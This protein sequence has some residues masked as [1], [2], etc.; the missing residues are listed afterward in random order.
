MT[1]IKKKLKRED[2]DRVYGLYQKQ[3][4]LLEKEQYL[5][6]LI[7][8]CD[9]NEHK[10][11]L[12][13]LLSAFKYLSS[14]DLNE[15]YNYISDRIIYKSGFDENTTQVAS[16]TID[17]EADSSQRVLNDIKVPLFKKGWC[18]VKTVNRFNDIPKNFKKGKNQII[19]IDEFIGSGKTVLGRI[20][21]IK[22]WIQGDFELK[23]CFLAGMDFGIELIEKCGYEVYCPLRLP[24][25][26][27]GRYVGAF[28]TNAIRR[29]KMLEE[30]MAPEVNEHR[31]ETFSLGYND[32]QALYS[33]ESCFGN[34]PNSVFP[35]FWWPRYLNSS[36]RDTILTRVQNGLK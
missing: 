9:T 12:V 20:K 29:M 32:T 22:E 10:D 8:L 7:N 2:F 24:K 1:D 36:S 6:E 21:N 14:K 11:L 16:I 28:K 33:L 3:P 34:T 25:G 26:I 15:Y 4:W 17:D 35:I 18:N 31:L 23:F 30:K 13:N 5:I 27:S 19:L